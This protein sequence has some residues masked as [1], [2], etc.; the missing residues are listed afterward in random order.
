VSKAILAWEKGNTQVQ[1]IAIF[2]GEKGATQ[3]YLYG[4][5][6]RRKRN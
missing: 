6:G 5:E 4:I 1:P 3:L 2:Q